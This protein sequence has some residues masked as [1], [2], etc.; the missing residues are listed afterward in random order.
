M[1]LYKLNCQ[2]GELSTGQLTPAAESTIEVEKHLESWLERSPWAVFEEPLLIIGR[3]PSAKT[4]EATVFPDLLA[5]DAAGNLVIIELKKGRAPREVTAQLLEYAAWAAELAHDEIARIAAAYL[6]LESMDPDEELAA[7]FLEEFE[8]EEFPK[9]GDK[10]RL[11]I[12][13][14]EIPPS[15]ARVCRFLRS[16]HGIE[17]TCL[18]FSVFRT[19][20]GEIL[21]QSKEVVGSESDGPGSSVERTS[22]WLGDTPVKE[23]VW[24]A[25]KKL[26]RDDPGRVFSPKE[27]ITVI[28][29][30]HPSFNATTARCQLIADCVNHTSRH[31][32]PGGQDRY[33]TVG[34]GQ[35]RLCRT[36]DRSFDPTG[37]P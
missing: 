6:R 32:Y 27:V 34:K 15:V 1:S 35:Y 19:E 9:L 7:M 28:L 25:V 30:Q 23:V 3:Q 4:M 31:H 8:A 29:E 33:W 17:L 21:V 22:R 5:L 10:L 12:A 26:T 14:E 24:T 18:S 20:A 36:E 13:A 16:R 2:G 37:I 11:V